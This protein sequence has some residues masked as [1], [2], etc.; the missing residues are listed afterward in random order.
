MPATHP[1]DPVIDAAAGDL[2]AFLGQ[3]KHKHDLTGA[4]FCWLI[5]NSLS[6]RLRM[7][8]GEERERL[9]RE[10]RERDRP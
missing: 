7:D 4:E 6:L 5:G 10:A 9:D 3:W 8:A 1:R 2:I